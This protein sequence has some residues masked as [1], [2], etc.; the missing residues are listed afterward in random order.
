LFFCVF[1]VCQNGQ[2]HF[3][4]N[5]IHNN[6]IAGVEIVSGG[7]P[8]VVSNAISGGTPADDFGICGESLD[9]YFSRTFTDMLG[10]RHS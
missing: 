9:Q 5:N 10:K 6:R 8:E 2:G 3:S 7:N 4:G 1:S